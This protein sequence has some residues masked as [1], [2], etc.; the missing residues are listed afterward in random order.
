M[1]Q[2]LGKKEGSRIAKKDNV[3]RYPTPSSQAGQILSD[4]DS[5]N[6]V[7]FLLAK[8]PS[9][10]YYSPVAKREQQISV[11]P[12]GISIKWNINSLIQDL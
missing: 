8:E 4:V 5:L 2:L 1:W 11:F 3:Y 9:L 7:S 10:A 12:K 6:P